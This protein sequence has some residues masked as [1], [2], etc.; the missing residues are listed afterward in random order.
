MFCNMAS[1]LS[2]TLHLSIHSYVNNCYD[3]RSLCNL[4]NAILIVHMFTMLQL[5]GILRPDQPTFQPILS[6]MNSNQFYLRT[7]S[8]TKFT[9]AISTTL[10]INS[11]LLLEILS[12]WFG[13]RTFQVSDTKDSTCKFNHNLRYIR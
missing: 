10:Q 3:D 2:Q 9:K 6:R 8:L 11:I 13:L 12:L 5:R 1:H 4:F 7:M